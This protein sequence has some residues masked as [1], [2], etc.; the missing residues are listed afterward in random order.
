MDYSLNKR[1]MSVGPLKGKEVFVASAVCQ[2]QRISFDQ[3][4]ERMAEDSTVGQADVAAVFYKFRNILNRLCS[5]GYIVDGGPLGTFRPTFS[6]KAVEK[7]E[8]FK[9][10]E[11][12]SKTQILF[13]PTPDFRQ[14]KNVEFFRVA[15]QEKKKGKP[16]QISFFISMNLHNTTPIKNQTTSLLTFLQEGGLFYCHT[17]RKPYLR[18]QIKINLVFLHRVSSETQDI[19]GKRRSVMLASVRPET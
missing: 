11:C 15:K 19:V 13:T 3:L 10:S 1:K 2:K 12:I 5:Q 9:P 8:D 7:E 4:C 6:S 16:S 17:E 14:L 18:L